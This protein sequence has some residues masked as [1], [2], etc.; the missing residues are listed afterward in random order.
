MS[1]PAERKQDTWEA[2][3]NIEYDTFRLWTRRRHE[4]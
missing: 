1:L 4:G 2:L 3:T